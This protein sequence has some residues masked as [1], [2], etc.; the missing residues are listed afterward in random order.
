MFKLLNRISY[1]VSFIMW[2]II[3]FIFISFDSYNLNSDIIIS[4]LV[5][6]IV[7]WLIFKKLFLSK[8][9]IESRLQYF[10][11]TIK[12]LEKTVSPKV[13]TY[14]KQE[15]PLEEI[16]EFKLEEKLFEKEVEFVKSTEKVSEPSKFELAIKSFFAENLLAKLW[17]ILVFLWVLF[18]LSLVYTA[19]WPVWKLIIWFSIWFAIYFAWV[20]LEKK[21]YKN[22]GKILIG[23]WILINYLVILWWRYLIWDSIDN[24][25]LSI[26][27]TFIFLIFNTLFAVVTSLVYQSRTLLLFSFIFAFLNPLLIWG[28]W[29][30][31]YT[32]VWY[33]L[34]VAFWWLFLSLKQKDLLLTIWIFILSN[35]LFLV[36]PMNLEIHWIIKLVSSAIISIFSIWVVYKIDS[37]KVPSLLIW[38][39][40]FL[41][42]LLWTGNVYIKE[43]TS[44]ISYM[45]TIVLYFSVWLYFFLKTSIN[46]ILFLLFSP[47]LIILGL[48][49]SWL[50]I[51]IASV[52][53][54]VILVYLVWFVFVK[55]KLRGA[56]KY[57]FFIVLW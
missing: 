40:I 57:F 9:F 36:A 32:L 17:G 48:C 46:S 27:T 43:T 2:F 44:F 50:L 24:N 41:M 55:D 26:W 35:I 6:W 56:F 7:V 54:L 33:S 12:S 34:I 10:A 37:N 51:N 13:T 53:A 49:F 3:C 22:E 20:L 29:D 38:A 4:S 25:L 16:K 39:Y 11:D 52:L 23:V 45:I 1:L 30:N 28:N 47:I 19:I 42:L 14:Q 18:L 8:K 21:D 5:F 31:P 15:Q